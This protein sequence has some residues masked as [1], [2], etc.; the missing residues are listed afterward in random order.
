[1]RILNLVTCF[2]STFRVKHQNLIEERKKIKKKVTIVN[3]LEV[4]GSKKC[5]KNFFF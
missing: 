5:Y 1:M 4:R 3:L 2:L